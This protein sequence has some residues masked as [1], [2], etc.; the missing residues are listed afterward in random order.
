MDTMKYQDQKQTAPTMDF[1]RFVFD[2][3]GCKNVR[4]VAAC[5]TTSLALIVIATGSSESLACAVA[6]GTHT[7]ALTAEFCPSQRVFVT[8]ENL[9]GTPQTCYVSVAG[10]HIG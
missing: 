3:T 6:S 1:A 9:T 4:V 8:C 10:E 7:E 2:V 5:P